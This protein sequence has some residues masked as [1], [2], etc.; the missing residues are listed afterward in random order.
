MD[1]SAIEIIHF[2]LTLVCNIIEFLI[3]FEPCDAGRYF[4]ILLNN[5]FYYYIYILRINT[6]IYLI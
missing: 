6:R 4:L 3:V 1:S 5:C 2:T